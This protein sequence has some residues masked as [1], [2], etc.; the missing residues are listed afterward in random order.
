[1]E[2]NLNNI[3]PLKDNYPESDQDLEK[4]FSKHLIQ[5]K[6]KKITNVIFTENEI[7]DNKKDL[8]NYTEH[9]LIKFQNHF[10]TDEN[11]LFTFSKQEY[12]NDETSEKESTSNKNESENTSQNN[13]FKK[14]INET[15][16]GDL[17]CSYLDSF[18]KM[19]IK[20]SKNFNY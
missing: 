1:M 20:N 3:S 17:Y 9:N 15:T 14:V 4:I 7:K 19:W 6:L 8:E 13:Y 16:E 10:L 18:D 11:E 2:K 12:T 5:P